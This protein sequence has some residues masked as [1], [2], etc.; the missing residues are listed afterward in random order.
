MLEI[1]GGKM[2]CTTGSY[3]QNLEAESNVQTVK[4]RLQGGLEVSTTNPCK[5]RL[6]LC[7]A[8]SMA[9]DKSLNEYLR[10]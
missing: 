8:S 4:N 3:D 10:R 2:G 6:E 9:P 5:Q 1:A 7:A